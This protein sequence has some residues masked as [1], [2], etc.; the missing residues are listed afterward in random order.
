MK[1]RSVRLLSVLL[2]LAMLLS[3]LPLMAF[4]Y[5]RN[6]GT[7]HELCTSLSSQ[8]VAYYTGDYSPDALVSYE[9]DSTGSCLQAVDSELYNALQTL[10]TKTMTK[11]VSYSSLTGYWPD[12]DCTNNSN[13][14]IM[15]YADSFKGEISREHVWPKSR[16]SFLKSGGGSDIHH[17]RPSDKE[18]NSK[19]S[20]YMFGNVRELLPNEHTTYDFDGKTVLWYNM[21]Y[22]EN[23]PEELSKEKLGMVEINDNI[24]GD[25]ARI[26]LYVYTRWEEKNLFENDPNATIGSGDDEN[27]GM[28]VIKDLDTLLQWCEQDPVDTWEMGRN[29][30]CQAVQGNR[31]VFIDYP[32]LAWLLFGE[33]PPADM[34]VPEKL[35]LDLTDFTVT[36]SSNNE[37]WGTVSQSGR[38]IIASPKEGYFTEDHTILSGE[39]TVSREG[40][41]FT[42]KPQSDCSIQINFAP[43]KT[44]TV[45][46]GGVA[47][48]I[49]GY[50]G[51]EITLP[52]GKAPENYR[53]I[54]WVT[55]A[56]E[57]TTTKPSFYAA[58]SSYIPSGDM[59]FMALYAYSDGPAFG[60]WTRVTQEAE[61]QSGIKLVL[62]SV[63]NG[64]VAAPLYSGGKYL[65]HTTAT[66]SQDGTIIEDLPEEAVTLLLGGEA[67]AWTLAAEDGSLLG[68]AGN[69]NIGWGTGETLWKISISAGNATISTSNES[70]GRILYN[71]GSPRFT[72]YTNAV[73][74][75]LML[76]QLYY[77][78]DTEI[79]YTTELAGCEHK[80]AT[81]HEAVSATCTEDGSI[82]YYSCDLC[83]K[84]AADQDFAQLL[85]TAETVVA[86]L[87]HDYEGE[88][89]APTCTEGGKTVY[90]C[91]VCEDSYEDELTEA[92]G[93]D[94]DEGVVIT[95]PTETEEGVKTYT[96]LICEETKTESIPALGE[97][98]QE[99]C[100]NGEA[101]GSHTFTDM[102]AYEDWAHAGI[103]YALMHGLFKGMSETTFAPNKTMTRAMLV[104]VLWRY[105]EEPEAE[106]APF[107]DVA[108]DVWYAEA[109]AW[110]AENGIVNGMGDGTF[111]PDNKITREQLATILFRF[112]QKLE[113]NTEARAELDSFPD[114]EEIQSYAAEAL[115]WAVA[116]KLIN[117]VSVEGTAYLR[118]AGDATRAQVATILMRFLEGLEA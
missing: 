3:S 53:F 100:E 38:R 107:D 76:P 29:D 36:A 8:A 78:L 75:A 33:T 39:A 13:S 114:V 6:T 110:A 49:K 84:L 44:V 116:M 58:G 68:A 23:L 41:I 99:D 5:Q 101:C 81:Y 9:T 2:V 62:A 111:R 17:L 30:A 15:F 18:V 66:F 7:R 27:N 50:A 4:A 71:V 93:H 72:T 26:L 105:A 87:G 42:V 109:V 94:W 22:T 46:F 70:Y 104:T 14:Y 117:G 88:L 86:A 64:T 20:N 11:S 32:E 54:G 69:K 45:S 57:D 35:P 34:R 10:M 113:L 25:T 85:T 59:E 48:A 61:L 83:G 19:R 12:T 37:A 24:K 79:H 67:G 40:N 31:N 74:N 106:K 96:C 52:D 51:E 108:E 1:H 89:I 28:R 65:T 118:P 16:A 103:D 56:V 73:S 97:E 98:N 21:S 82:A 95:E 102:P 47:E 112:A 63:E 43:K 55:E 91:S 77:K 92:L 115:Q 80:T 90:T 60:E